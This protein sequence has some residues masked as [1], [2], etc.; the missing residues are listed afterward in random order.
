MTNQ[1]KTKEELTHELE[2]LRRRVAELESAQAE[3]RG[4]RKALEESEERFRIL[5]ENAPLGYQSLDEDGHILEVNEAWLNALGYS[6]QEVI[7]KWFGD[8]LPPAY[9]ERFR[10]NFPKFKEAGEIHWA[11]YEMLK[12][13]GSTISVA[14]DGRIGRDQWGRFTQTHCIMHDITELKKRDKKLREEKEKAERYLDVASVMIMALNSK[15]EVTLINRYGEQILGF[16]RDEIIGKNW[17]DNF[18]PEWDRDRVKTAF[19]R[20]MAGEMESPGSFENPV[21]TRSGEE[22]LIAWYNTILMTETGELI[23]TLSSG[24]DI[25]DRK[26]AE[27]AV[28]RQREELQLVLDSVPALIFYKDLD[29]RMVQANKAWFQTFRFSEHDVI[30]KSLSD[31]LPEEQAAEIYRDD[32]E[33]IT[34]RQPKRNILEAFEIDGKLRT[35]ITDKIPYQNENGEV[36]GIIGFAQDITE[37]EQAEAALREREQLLTTVLSTSP[38]AIGLTTNR[39]LEW[40][41]EAWAKM[42]GFTSE[43]EYLGKSARILY[44]SEEEFQRAGPLLYSNLDDG[45]TNEADALMVR[46]DGS[47]FDARLRMRLVDISDKSKGA[48]TAITDVSKRKRMEEALRESEERLDMALQGAD[49]GLWDLDVKSGRAVVNERAAQMAG[50]K[51]HELDPTISSFERLL[52]PEDKDRV[53]AAMNAHMTGQSPALAE[54]YRIHTKSGEVRWN[55]ARGKVVERDKD[56]YAVRMAGTFLDIT[57]RKKSELALRRLATAVE[58]AE[59]AI[60]ITDRTGTIHYINPAFEK[61]TGYSRDEALG[62]KPS[63]L[64]SGEHDEEFYRN[65]WNTITQ[66]KVW[67][68]R[69]VNRRKDGS[70]YREDATISPVRDRSGSIVN[71]VAVKRDVTQELALQ[72]QLLHAQKMEAIGT[73]AGG[74][75]H[76]FN[77]ILQVTLGFSELLLSERTEQDPEYADLQ[78][79][80]QS[81][82]SGAD[83]VQRILTFSR[84]IETKPIP[85]NINRHV[86]QTKEILR[87]TI[88]RMIDIELDL[89]DDVAEINA[90]PNQLEQ[91]LMNLAVNARDAMPDGGKL[92]IKTE[93]VHLDEAYCRTHAGVKPGKYVAL[94]ISDNGHGMGRQTLE[95]IFEPFYTT[96]EIGRG[97]GLG[98]AIVYGI[99]Q[100]HGGHITCESKP[101]RGTKF[102]IYLPALEIEQLQDVSETAEMPA[103]GTE[104]V[105][106]VDDEDLVRDLGERI[107]TRNGYT[108]LT[109]G[110]GREALD[111]YKGQKD[112]IHLVIL[113]LI[114]PEMGGKQ[115]LEKILKID[116]KVKVLVASGHSGDLPTRESLEIGAKGFVAKP[117]KV[118][119]LLQEVRKVLDKDD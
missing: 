84:R 53:L 73:L 94:T 100:Q 63:I 14:F 93:N 114:M 72:E 18:L 42:F 40:A 32:L 24:V 91:V 65:L 17:F 116:P 45:R 111:L 39:R 43:K 60:V 108:V 103:F 20:I 71:F 37:R 62:G 87:R 4:T 41:N 33:V 35:F 89:S 69:F 55:L 48:I 109:A 77:N 70:L 19:L 3:L 50:Y 117:F 82:R 92:I 44:P 118:K 85:L 26:K 64:K 86:R 66:G 16:S 31:F 38:V 88:P 78:K 97:T 67:K 58:Q 57:E 7:G 1:D 56:G 13:D 75:A 90:D 61:I 28:R 6:R 119:D 49:L 29:N 15:G 11:E 115:C 80:V 107:L 52:H 96:K 21:L 2:K 110:N 112:R 74:I 36:V 106:L 98:L 68:G 76:D 113:D 9:L 95:H 104:T 79:I 81:A 10:V 27:D 25:T 59:E 47:L 51:L 101:G 46:R 83:L 30:G 102:Q 54:E 105:L 22:R 23:G 12:K 99:V 5:Y 34:S 8:L